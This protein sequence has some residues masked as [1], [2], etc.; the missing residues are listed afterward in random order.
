[1]L[2]IIL[3]TDHW[4]QRW[5]LMGETFVVVAIASDLFVVCQAVVGKTFIYFE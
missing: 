2:F 4:V 3:T 5:V 1:L